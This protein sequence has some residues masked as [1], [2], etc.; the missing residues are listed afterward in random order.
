[1]KIVGN[2]LDRRVRVVI[3]IYNKDEDIRALAFV[4]AR[5]ANSQF[6]KV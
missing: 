6:I 4:V 1:V 3:I 2:S 5:V